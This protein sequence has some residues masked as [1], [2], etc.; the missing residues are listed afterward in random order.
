M[1][2]SSH[3]RLLKL[4]ICTTSLYTHKYEKH[5]SLSY[6]SLSNQDKLLSEGALQPL[7]ALAHQE[8]GDIET[9]RYAVFAITNISAAKETHSVLIDA[10]LTDLITTLLDGVCMYS[11]TL[12]FPLQHSVL[13]LGAILFSN[14]RM[15]MLCQPTHNLIFFC[16][17]YHRKG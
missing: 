13:T 7:L 12:I 11:S 1:D 8:N 4:N 6:L 3:L 17:Y 9:Q 10:G 15:R 5:S 2:K 16:S 14:L